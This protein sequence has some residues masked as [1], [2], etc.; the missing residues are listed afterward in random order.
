MFIIRSNI[1]SDV[2]FRTFTSPKQYIINF[3]KLREAPYI[4][5][6]ADL[7]LNN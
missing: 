3:Q 4:N 2:F 5:A 1:Y 6:N 7:T